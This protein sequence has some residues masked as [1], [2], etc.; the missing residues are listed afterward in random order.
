MAWQ[1]KIPFGYR[2]VNGEI[3]VNPSEAQ[4]VKGIFSSFLGGASFAAIADAMTTSGPRYHAEKPDWNKH[5]VKRML[6]NVK[7]AGTDDY[8]AIITADTYEQAQRIRVSKTENYTPHPDCNN[9]VKRKLVCAVC[10]FPYNRHAY[11]KNESR[12]W[13]CSN[14]E[15]GSTLKTTDAEL[16]SRVVFLLNQLIANPALL[17]M[18]AALPVISAEAER[19]KNEINRELSKA[20][21]DEERT[22][23]LIFAQA[24]AKYAALGDRDDLEQK[25]E[26][27][28]NRIAA[29]PPLTAFNSE[30]FHAAVTAVMV[31]AGGVLTL[32]LISGA[33]IVEEGESDHASDN[34]S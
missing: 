19:L 14:E 9:V 10:G 15:C 24:A 21:F 33:R 26:S 1:R 30:F 16:E 20:D 6:E 34:R 31:G 22:K 29:M 18:E 23:A 3:A 32:R 13:H 11:K 25:A 12:W 5:M 7:Y 28:K 17:D 4:A 8:P 27:L 2:I